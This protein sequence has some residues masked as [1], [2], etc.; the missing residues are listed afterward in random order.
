[1]LYL[2]VN[3]TEKSLFFFSI[4][5]YIY[6]TGDHIST[7]STREKK[8]S[9]YLSFLMLMMTTRSTF[10]RQFEN[11]VFRSSECITKSLDCTFDA[12]EGRVC[13]QVPSTKRRRFARRV[14]F[15]VPGS[16]DDDKFAG[17]TS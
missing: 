9:F 3:K 6:V 11:T 14:I 5:I 2:A 13:V 4:P 8:W 1:M 7:K 17:R 15:V 12:P 10:L 16:V